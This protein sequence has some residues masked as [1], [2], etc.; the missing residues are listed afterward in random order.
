MQKDCYGM[1]SVTV[2]VMETADQ[3]IKST[4]RVLSLL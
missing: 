2:F 4:K 3:L 1:D